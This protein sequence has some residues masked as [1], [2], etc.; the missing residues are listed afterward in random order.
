MRPVHPSSGAS[1][2]SRHRA[3][4]AC[5]AC[6]HITHGDDSVPAFRNPNDSCRSTCPIATARHREYLVFGSCLCW[7][8]RV[9]FRVPRAQPCRLHGVPF[10]WNRAAPFAETRPNAPDPCLFTRYRRPCGGTDCGLATRLMRPHCSDKYTPRS[11]PH[12]VSCAGRPIGHSY[13]KRSPSV[14]A[15]RAHHE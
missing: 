12:R 11:L 4:W 3:C 9:R 14:G 15:G 2:S 13:V 6:T 5:N 10:G 1:R 7:A 8:D